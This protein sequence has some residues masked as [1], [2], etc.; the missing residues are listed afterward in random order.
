MFLG[1]CAVCDH[2]LPSFFFPNFRAFLTFPHVDF[3]GGGYSSKPRAYLT[4]V[5]VVLPSVFD[6]SSLKKLKPEE[7]FFLLLVLVPSPGPSLLYF[8]L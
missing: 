3:L 5:P 8:H 4:L 1:I 6:S 2:Q 7:V